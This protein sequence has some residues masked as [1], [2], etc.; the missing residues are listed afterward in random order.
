MN[1]E[2]LI[3]LVQV[4]LGP[5][6]E[7]Y[8]VEQTEDDGEPIVHFMNHLEKT[9]RV[10][11]DP[12]EMAIWVRE[13][14]RSAWRSTDITSTFEVELDE[15]IED[16]LYEDDIEDTVSDESR[17]TLLEW[18][19]NDY[20]VRLDELEEELRQFGS[21]MQDVVLCLVETADNLTAQD[22]VNDL[23]VA[24]QKTTQQNV[25]TVIRILEK[26]MKRL[27]NEPV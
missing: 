15:V 4:T 10:G 8:H 13:W 23:M 21:L 17:I 19:S 18:E 3:E 25:D 24:N 27:G 26:L 2:A 14:V 22:R 20:S 1:A 12:T 6:W 16:F 11:Y 5:H 9:I 7:V